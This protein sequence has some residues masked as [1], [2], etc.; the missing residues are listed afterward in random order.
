MACATLQIISLS[1]FTL[2]YD[3]IILSTSS[4]RRSEEIKVP[5]FSNQCAPGSITSANMDDSVG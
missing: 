3:S 5:V 2:P 4:M 1:D